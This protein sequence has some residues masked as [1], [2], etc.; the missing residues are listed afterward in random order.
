VR[1][2]REAL[3][4]DVALMVDVNQQWDRTTA[5]R[6]GR[7]LEELELAWIEEPLDAHDLD[8]HAALA[9]Q[10][11]TPVGSGEMLASAADACAFV[12]R[13][14]VDVIMHDAPRI[15]GITPFLQVA[16]AARRRGLVLAPHFVMELHIHLAAAYEHVAWV[17]HFEW[18]EPLFE[19]RLEISGGCIQVPTRLGLGLSLSERVAGW[20][21]T[22]DAFGR[23]G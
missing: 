4:A 1:A 6:M 16:E 17:E 2:L 3:G 14:A 9:A 11:V 21:L 19:E 8:G 5:L 22:S 7:A 12:E 15:G 10:L 20:T 13:G 18:L 23:R